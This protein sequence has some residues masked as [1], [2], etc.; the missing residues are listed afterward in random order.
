[1]IGLWF[2]TLTASTVGVWEEGREVDGCQGAWRRGSGSVYLAVGSVCG[3]G[4]MTEM[5]PPQGWCKL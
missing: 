5:G 4:Q 3:L 2:R 1:M